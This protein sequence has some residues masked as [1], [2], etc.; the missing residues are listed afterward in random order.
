M[1]FFGRRMPIFFWLTL[2]VM[3]GVLPAWVATALVI[4]ASYVRERAVLD[5]NTIATVR[6]LT[7]ALDRYLFGVA[8]AIQVLATSP[9]LTS[10]DF[11]SFHAQAREVLPTLGGHA[12]ALIDPTGQQLLNTRRP[13]GEPLPRAAVAEQ[14]QTVF[15]SGKP[16]LSDFLVGAVSHQLQVVVVVPVIRDSSVPYVLV[17]SLLPLRLDEF[18]RHEQVPPDWQVTIFDRSGTIV[19][20]A[21]AA[22]DQLV[23]QKGSPDLLRHI[24]EAPRGSAILSKPEGIPL[25]TSFYRSELS[26]W[27]VATSVATA[28]LTAELHE[29]LWLTGLSVGGLS[30]V[31]LFFARHI[32]VRITHS[33][34]ALSAPALAVTTGTPIIVPPLEIAEA[35]EV[36]RALATA[37]RLL[38]HRARAR[39]EAEM[40]AQ[41]HLD[42]L[43]HMERVSI[44]GEMAAGIAHEL[45]QPL[46]A[47]RT[48]GRGCLRLLTTE[49]PDLGMLTDQVQE[50]V[51]QAGRATDVLTRLRAFVT[52][53]P[54]AREP[55]AVRPI[56]DA[57]IGL[58][59]REGARASVK[60]ETHIEPDLPAVFVDNIQI[61]QVLLNL[62]RNSID[63]VVSTNPDDRL[64]VVTARRKSPE[65]IEI[66]VADTGPGID[67]HVE[68][69]LFRPFATTKPRGM[70]MGL[71]ISRNI[72]EAHGG[73][74]RVEA[75]RS[76]C[77]AVFLFDLTTYVSAKENDDE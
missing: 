21:P 12:I 31:A 50:I 40:R 17:M 53:R 72:V 9:N 60:I 71:S 51:Q 47:I 75:G 48:N 62:L 3:I 35:D 74:L 15:Q 54:F 18:L 23:G 29:R 14:A 46:S 63:A 7:E 19:A 5:Q 26:G 66:S 28:G 37:G 10:R 36:G 27:S 34:R 1:R 33:I 65:S 76:G 52:N 20:R 70:G 4:R 49:K 42:E 41:A 30:L 2:L 38:E 64:I 59:A 67:D 8:S 39:V 61:E 13:Y 25:L 44:A 73:S 24:A 68:E 32:G 16:I 11:A 69:S 77:G 22:P 56:V 55:A 58:V 6:N 45:S 57:A 43:A